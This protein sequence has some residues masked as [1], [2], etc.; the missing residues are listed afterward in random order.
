M[1]RNSSDWSKLIEPMK[2]ALTSR[3]KSI[4]GIAIVVVG[5][6]AILNL[7]WFVTK[8]AQLHGDLDQSMVRRDWMI[9]A[10]LLIAALSL[11]SKRGFG[12]ML[13]LVALLWVLF[14]YIHWYFWTQR[15]IET[16]GMPRIPPWVPQ[17]LHLWG[18]TAWSVLVLLIA[19]ILVVW[20][21]AILVRTLKSSHHAGD[22][23][24][25]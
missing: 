18:G 21:L 1:P 24:S 16:L 4:S 9:A 13:S 14:E 3:S 5:V 15:L 2:I 7:V 11:A 6:T 8:Y 12:L 23:T 20:E 22:W 25:P 19:V 10:A 17:G